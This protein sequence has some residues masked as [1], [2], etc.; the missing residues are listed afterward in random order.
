MRHAYGNAHIHA[1]G[2][3]D[4]NLAVA[5]GDS[6][7][8]IHSDGNGR[9]HSDGDC[10]SRRIINT[11]GDCNGDCYGNSHSNGYSDR[12]AAAY[13]DATA[14]SNTAG[15]SGHLLFREF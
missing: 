7:G 9:I 3:S 4:T 5:N 6:D 1:N 8:H 15:P 12:I 13:T 14:S 11:N 10:D 2:D